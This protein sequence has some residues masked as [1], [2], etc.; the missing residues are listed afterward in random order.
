[1]ISIE[2]A[3]LFLVNSR[4]RKIGSYHIENTGIAQFSIIEA[5]RVNKSNDLPVNLE[6]FGDL[7]IVCT[8]F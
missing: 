5:R 3:T 8:R 2:F 1:M 6:G 7:Y 4:M